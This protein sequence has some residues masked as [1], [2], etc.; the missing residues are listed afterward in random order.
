[1]CGRVPKSSSTG[2]RASTATT[3]AATVT[4]VDPGTGDPA[5]PVPGLVPAT[6][7]EIGMRSEAIP[8]L[9]S[10]LSLWQLETDSELVFV[11]DA[12][13]PEAGLPAG[14]RGVELSTRHMPRR[15]LVLDADLA[16][17]RARFT[18]GN[19][20]GDRIPGAVERAAS[21]AVTVRDGERWLA[22]LQL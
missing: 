8:G 13:T 4:H 17:T 19:P 12:G 14:R 18:H 5:E 20:T 6:G 7:F 9:Q 21:L 3:A 10:S 16:W 22:S 15:W 11:G 2:V 1:G